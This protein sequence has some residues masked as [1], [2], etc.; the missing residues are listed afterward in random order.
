MLWWYWFRTSEERKAIHKET[1]KQTLAKPVF[2]GP[3]E[4]TGTEWTDV[5]ALPR[6]PPPH[7]LADTSAESS[8]PEAN[9]LSMFF[10]QLRARSEF[11]PESFGP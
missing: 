7:V 6:A 9:P 2:A 3:A 4:M 8:I 5:Q 1:E 10:R 11:P